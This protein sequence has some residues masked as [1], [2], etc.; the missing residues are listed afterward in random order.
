M[1]APA[2]PAAR[3]RTEHRRGHDDPCRTAIR[4]VTHHWNPPCERATTHALSS[5][6]SYHASSHLLTTDCDARQVLYAG[7]TSVAIA[8][9]N[10]SDSY[11]AKVS[12]VPTARPLTC[13]PERSWSQSGV[14]VSVVVSPTTRRSAPRAQGRARTSAACAYSAGH[15][16]PTRT[17]RKWRGPAASCR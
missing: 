16:R 4:C 11:S 3:T 13:R 5:Q 15:A 10:L 9:A 7:T 12:R 8:T 1:A 6:R 2:A 17:A 14:E